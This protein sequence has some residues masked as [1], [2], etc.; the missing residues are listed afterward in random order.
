[1][2][3]RLPGQ[4][5]DAETGLNQNYF[6]DYDPELGRYTTPDPMGLEG[7]L[8][9]YL[10]ADADPLSK[11][12]P[13]GLYSVDVHY[14]MTL[15]LARVAGVDLQTALTIAQATQHIDE[16]PDTWP[17]DADHPIESNN[18]LTSDARN[19]LSKYHFTT[20]S[21]DW[22]NPFD[23]DPSRTFAEQAY[24]LAFGTEAQSYIE[25]RYKNPTNPQLTRLMNASTNA[26]TPCARAQFFGEFLHA[27]EDSFTHRNQTNDPIR[28][29]AN[30]GHLAWGH[31]P[32]LTYNHV[33]TFSPFVASIGTWNQNE[34]RTYQMEYEVFVKMREFGGTTGKNMH[35]GQSIRFRDIADFLEDWNK[36]HDEGAKISALRAKLDNFG[37]GPLPTFDNICAT[38]KRQAYLGGLNQS[39]Y[40]GTILPSQTATQAQV[41]A[42][43]R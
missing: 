18:P 22:Y 30:T 36:I 16:N 35:T 38:V 33:V 20:S 8:N 19:K 12:D 23:Y 42:A 14:Y 9:P 3:L 6:R 27:F 17:L 25:R 1:M 31:S 10:Y 5:F 37:L 24:F 40:D 29:N 4:V 11:A 7:G 28:L 43:C 34:A 41:A 15:F 39:S 32:D 2:R 13:L 26:P 21:P